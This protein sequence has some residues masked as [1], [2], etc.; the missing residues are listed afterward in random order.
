MKA[1]LDRISKISI[2]KQQYLFRLAVVFCLCWTL[3]PGILSS[4]MEAGLVFG[5]LQELGAAQTGMGGGGYLEPI[6]EDDILDMAEPAEIHELEPESF[7]RTRPLLYGSY[8]IKQGDVIGNIA[9]NSGLH[10]D[11]LISVNNI[12]NTRL[13]QIGQ[14][15][16]V[17]NQDGILHTV[18]QGETLQRIATTYRQ[19]IAAIQLANELFG[20]KIQP[21]TALFIPGARLP[22]V[23]QQERIGTRFIW[24]VSGRITSSYGNRRSPFS[25][26]VQFHNGIDIAARHGTPVRAAMAGRVTS[27]G[28]DDVWGNTI[29]IT[30]GNYRTFYAH[31][32][33]IHV[34]TGAHV[35]AGQRVGSVGSTGIST[36]PHLHVTI[37]RNGVTVNPRIY[38]R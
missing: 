29:V 37:Y 5:Q 34:A 1:F 18:K 4:V 9:A 10:Q 22:L 21:N 28:Y 30:Q 19:D 27:A 38:L 32:S 2:E 23:E 25:G 26:I 35:T 7:S 20:D 13:I 14:V 15:L 33:E 36:G 11:T 8:S 3:L 12:R 24:P 16:H 17:P 6:S 31:M